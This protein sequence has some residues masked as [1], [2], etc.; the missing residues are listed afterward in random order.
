[1]V[2]RHGVD[3][4]STVTSQQIG[5]EFEPAGGLGL[6]CVEFACSPCTCVVSNCSGFLLKTFKLGQPATLNCP[7]ERLFASV[8]AL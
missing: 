4:V 7:C 5:S 6:F 8:L 3:V 2:R 1:M